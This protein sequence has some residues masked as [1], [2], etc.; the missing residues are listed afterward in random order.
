ML[1]SVCGTHELRFI[2]SNWVR[3]GARSSGINWDLHKVFSSCL[4][5]TNAYFFIICLSL[6]QFGNLSK[7]MPSLKTA[8]ELSFKTVIENEHKI[9]AWI[10]IRWHF[11]SLLIHDERISPINGPKCCKMI[12]LLGSALQEKIIHSRELCSY[13]GQELTPTVCLHNTERSLI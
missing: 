1:L 12:R 10:D 8:N 4:Y 9:L 7:L 5:T 6:H 3:H 2:L 13:S 11:R